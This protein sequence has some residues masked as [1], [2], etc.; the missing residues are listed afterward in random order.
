MTWATTGGNTIVLSYTE[1]KWLQLIWNFEL[2]YVSG[3][4]LGRVRGITKVVSA[5]VAGDKPW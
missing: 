5:I 2:R 1:A 4:D 3:S